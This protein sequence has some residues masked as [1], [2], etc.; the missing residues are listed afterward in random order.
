MLTKSPFW[1]VDLSLKQ[2]IYFSS[3]IQISSKQVQN[4]ALNII[5]DQ[6]L[7]LIE[8]REEYS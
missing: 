1:S 4:E 3:W 6:N 5:N 8:G 2:V 7:A